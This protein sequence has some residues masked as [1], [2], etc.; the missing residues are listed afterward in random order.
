MAFATEDSVVNDPLKVPDVGVSKLRRLPRLVSPQE[1]YNR[2]ESVLQHFGVPAEESN[3]TALAD[4]QQTTSLSDVQKVL[5]ILDA[6]NQLNRFMRV[7]GDELLIFRDRDGYSQ[8][9]TKIVLSP[10]TVYQ[11][12]ALKN[13]AAA[14]ANAPA[15]RLKGLRIAIDPGHMSNGDWVERTGKFVKDRNGNKIS[16][17]VIN[18][19]TSL[20]LKQELEKLG[21][22]VMVTREGAAPVST[23]TAETLDLNAFGKAALRERSLEDWFQNLLTSAPAGAALYRSVEQHPKFQALF[24]NSARDNY[25]ILREDLAA[26][27]DVMDE[28]N[29]DISL[30]IHY[31]AP[32]NEVTSVSYSRVKTYVHGSIAPEE[33]ATQDDRLH[34]LKRMLDPVAADASFSLAKS[35]VNSLG[36]NLNLKMDGGGGGNSVAVAPGVFSRNLY[37]TRK[38]HGHAHTYVE[39]LHY[40]DPNEFRAFLAKDYSIVIDGQQTFYSERLR[41][42]ALAI[43]DGVVN[44]VAG[45]K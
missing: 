17:A 42:V 31:D 5:R 3:E 32:V 2:K 24:K 6:G 11:S 25:F 38:M 28:F 20:V 18:L 43:K 21:A 12:D 26:R 4:F 41:Q 45:N 40:N 15:E 13:I 37:I 35:V 8:E 33:W 9:D 23:L 29:P 30:V 27:V 7:S 39:C 16:E 1:L 19:Q 44:F 10:E 36:K 14:R 22:I 34:V